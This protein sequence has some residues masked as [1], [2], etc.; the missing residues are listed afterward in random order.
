[1]T[2]HRPMLGDLAD[3]SSPD[4]DLAVDVYCKHAGTPL[5]QTTVEKTVLD[6]ALASFDGA[7]NGNR[8][9]GGVRKAS[10]M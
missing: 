5:P 2:L 1:M 10:E 8:S 7:S 3:P 4:Y 9:R 6:V